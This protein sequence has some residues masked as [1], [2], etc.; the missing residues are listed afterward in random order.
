MYYTKRSE[1]KILVKAKKAEFISQLSKNIKSGAN[2]NC[3]RFKKLKTQL[4]KESSLN[5]FDMLNFCRF[6]KNLYSKP[7]LSQ[8]RLAEL[9]INKDEPSSSMLENS[10][11]RDIT[12]DELGGAI[13]QLK[14]GK[15]VSEDLIANEFLRSSGY[16]MR[17]TICHLFNECLKIGAYPWN[18]SLVNP[19]HKKRKHSRPK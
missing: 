13:N 7:P 12:I 4:G 14:L 9:V 11:N 5:A 1:Y 16:S 19:L 17:L 18:P 2:I 6:F 15:A 10:I 8:E 3:H